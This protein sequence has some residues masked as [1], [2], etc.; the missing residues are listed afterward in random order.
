MDSRTSGGLVV[1]IV[2]FLVAIFV[3]CLELYNK[4]RR[5]RRT[6]RVY[7]RLSTEPELP[8]VINRGIDLSSDTEDRWT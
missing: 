2:T 7:E 5:K 8:G 3:F 1:L 4:R 6:G